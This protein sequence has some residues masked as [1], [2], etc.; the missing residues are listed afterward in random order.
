MYLYNMISRLHKWIVG[1]ALIVSVA[2]FNGFISNSVTI[3][4]STELVV[5]TKP[6]TK[7]ATFYVGLI[8]SSL[9]DAFDFSFKILLNHYNSINKVHFI[10]F[11]YEALQYAGYVQFETLINSIHQDNYHDIFAG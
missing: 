10:S 9:K 3:K 7:T 11:K 5:E 6:I 4:T 2:S 1:L 8:N